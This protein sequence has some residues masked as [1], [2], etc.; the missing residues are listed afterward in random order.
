MRVKGGMKRNVR[1]TATLMAMLL[2][3][4]MAGCGDNG[5]GTKEPEE[6]TESA[7]S[8]AKETSEDAGASTSQQD[9]EEVKK[10]TSEQLF[11]DFLAGKAKVYCD[12]KEYEFNDT[13]A[14]E[15]IS[16]YKD[17]NGYTLKEL[18]GYVQGILNLIPDAEV[19]VNSVSHAMLDCGGDGEPELLLAIQSTGDIWNMDSDVQLVLK[20]VDGKLQIVN[21]LVGGYRSE[22]YFMNSQGVICNSWYWGMGN[23]SNYKYLDA[24][25]EEQFLYTASYTYPLSDRDDGLYAAAAKIAERDDIAWL[26]DSINFVEYRFTPYE[27]GEDESKVLKYSYR[28]YN[29]DDDGEE[30]P[31]SVKALMKETFDTAGVTLYEQDDIDK[32]IKDRV[33]ECGLAEG[34]AEEYDD[35]FS[36]THLEEEEFW[37]GKVCRVKTTAEFME[38]IGNDTMIYLEPGTYNLTQWLT[39]DDQMS[40]VPEHLEGD[41]ASENPAGV[42]YGGYDE[43]SWEITIC[44]VHNMK[45]L[46][47]DSQNPAHIVC[48]CPMA[49]V[50]TFDRC[51]FVTLENVVLGHEVEPGHCD[52]NVVDFAYSCYYTVKDC[53]MYGCGAYGLGI[54]G[55]YGG[56]IADSVIHDCTYGCMYAIDAGYVAINGT[57]F[58]NCAEYTMFSATGSNLNFYDCSFKKLK[59][60]MVYVDEYSYVSFSE[61]QFDKDSLESIQNDEAYKNGRVYLY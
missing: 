54:L 42:T 14:D 49:A 34:A 26:Y 43:A 7:E 30:V 9:Q 53:D 48:E 38:A 59:G 20:N 58:E 28:Y 40:K 22:C 16:L 3:F 60:E 35:D 37:P 15:S 24:S 36:W 23:V 4:G 2:A 45:I 52:G 47:A 44:N 32:M 18:V 10:V 61:C 5:A 56:E 19:C 11:R 51:G 31:E 13:V 41:H 25:G 17:P 39:A 1:M 8:S 27:E 33:R 46:S 57:K 21:R 55:G 29:W 50:L 12:L 6:K